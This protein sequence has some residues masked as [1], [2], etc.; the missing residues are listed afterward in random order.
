MNNKTINSKVILVGNGINRTYGVLSWAEL[1]GQI[2]TKKLTKEEMEALKNVPYPL[3]PV[4]LTEDNIDIKMK[5]VAEEL[6][7]FKP[8]EEESKLIQN[9]MSLPIEAILTTNYT[10]EIEKSVLPEFTCKV[11]CGSKFRKKIYK[12]AGK[13]EVNQLHTCFHVGDDKPTIWHIHG[14]AAKPDTM[15]LGHY[16]YGKHLAQIQQYVSK[17]IARYKC[18][19]SKGQIF[20]YQ[21]W[22]D[23]FL[24]CNVYIVGLGMDMSEMDLWWLV[25]C[26]KRHFKDKKTVLFK[27]DITKEQELLAKTYGV[28]VVKDGLTDKDFENYYKW[29]FDEI[30]SR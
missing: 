25:N 18:A 10:Y 30:R 8:K 14:E 23:Y 1:I 16:Y 29:V 13:Y 11:G 5:A 6:S 24:L 15:V 19:V 28:E 20:N 9:L 26:K 27:S 21:S 4:I 3:Q 17:L 2:Q 12:S 22:V 7:S